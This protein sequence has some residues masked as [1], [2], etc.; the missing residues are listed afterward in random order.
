MI[1]LSYNGI[2][3][4]GGGFQRCRSLNGVVLINLT[5]NELDGASLKSLMDSTRS[6]ASSLTVVM[7]YN[8]VSVVPGTLL[9]FV[10]SRQR[11]C[12]VPPCASTIDLTI[13]LS[14]NPITV[15][16]PT[17]WSS[18]P[19][20]GNSQTSHVRNLIIDLSNPTAAFAPSTFAFSHVRWSAT[21]TSTVSINLGGNRGVDLA[22]ICT[23]FNTPNMPE[24]KNISISLPSN[25]YTQISSGVFDGCRINHLDLK[26]NNITQVSSH[27]FG[28]FCASLPVF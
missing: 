20:Q 15:V 28:H 17:A 11:L 24:T 4:V 13:D 23:L 14:H 25:S 10:N 3:S 19:V 26:Y 27:A 2:R 21:S 5:G 9:G 1:E 8:N 22:T 12:P 16:S 7:A 6:C 18:L